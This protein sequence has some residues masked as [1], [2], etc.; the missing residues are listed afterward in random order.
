VEGRDGGVRAHRPVQFGPLALVVALAVASSITGLW[1]WFAYDDVSLILYNPAAHSLAALV[2]VWS[3]PYWPPGA[4]GILYRPITSALFAVEWVAGHGSARTFHTVSIVLYAAL[5]AL[6]Y[7]LARRLLPPAAALIA[8]ALFAVHPVHVEVVANCVG[9]G[10]LLAA[11]AVVAAT[12]VYLDHRGDLRA[13]WIIGA[14]YAVGILSKEHAVVLPLV[15]GAAELTVVADEQHRR[16]RSLVVPMAAALGACL[17]ARYAAIGTLLGDAPDPVLAHAIFT[18]R[19]WTM[20][21]VVREWTRLLVWPARLSFSYNP[22]AIPVLTTL[23]GAAVA[24]ALIVVAAASLA[25][26][27]RRRVPTLTLGIIWAAVTLLPVTNI[28]FVSGVLLAERSLFLPSV[29][30]VLALGAALAVVDQRVRG[31]RAIA[32]GLAVVVIACGV[33]RSATRQVVWRNDH[34]LFAAGV[35]DA[36]SDYHAR[37]LWA[38]ELFDEGNTVE[39]MREAR[40]S[41]ALSGGYPL[42]LSLL[43]D[44][45]AKADSCDHAI[46]LWRRALITMPG[47]PAP[48]IGL[49]SCLLR[50]GAPADARAVALEGIAHGESDPALH[51]IVASADSAESRLDR[52]RR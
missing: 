12:I 6:V 32:V 16:I 51:R 4:G 21:G 19:L 45:Y 23:G 48:R 37:Y 47:L 36:P 17:V 9:Q 24:G 7:L 43:A 26:I 5:S 42:A 28:V 11:L 1:N 41:I 22:P 8:A 27:A 25:V 34:T 46:P 18:T 44:G 38:D 29:G 50:V 3:Q 14:L 35:V 40:R 30:M 2:H 52:R 33:W 10:E 49:A 31:P 13:A 15:L 39:A 20:L